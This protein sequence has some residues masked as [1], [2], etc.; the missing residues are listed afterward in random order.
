M[1]STPPNDMAGTLRRVI[2]LVGL[3]NLAYFGIEFTVALAIGSVSLFADSVD[4]LED[5]SVNFLIVAALGWTARSRAR[6]GMALAAILLVPA[7]ATLWT[8][9]QKFNLPTPPQPLVLS[10]T[11]LGALV[12][13]FSC[14]LM[15]TRYRYH[16]GSLTRA[17]F[18]SARNDVLANI[19]IIVAGLVTAFL[20]HAAWPDLLVGLGI[21]AMNADAAREVWQAARNEHRAAA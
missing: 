13:N 17:A 1:N 21:A 8:A 5:A 15:L 12:V 14:A 9:W 19:A 18:L 16:A 10:V 6:V 3:L 4:F 7:L 20:W 11:G 2:S